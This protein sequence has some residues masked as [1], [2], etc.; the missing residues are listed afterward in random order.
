MHAFLQRHAS[1]VMGVLHGF[2]RMRF[3]GTLR[4]LAHGGGMREFLFRANV[5]FKDFKDYVISIT[6]QVREAAQQTA[7]QAGRP[8]KYLASSATNKEAIARQ[9]A[10]SDGGCPH[11]E[12]VGAP[13]PARTNSSRSAARSD[14]R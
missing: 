5:L 3:R 13:A 12:A 1:R 4:Q 10:A 7:D 2:D 6:D 14:S 11:S 9:I 8:L